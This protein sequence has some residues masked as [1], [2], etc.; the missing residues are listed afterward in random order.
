MIRLLSSLFP[1]RGPAAPLGD[2]P[3]GELLRG[4]SDTDV[5]PEILLQIL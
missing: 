1:S 4:A 3:L 2:D 5:A